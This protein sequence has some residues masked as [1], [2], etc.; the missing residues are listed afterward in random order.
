MLF[1]VLLQ[2]S[3]ITF[4]L[5]TRICLN[6]DISFDVSELLAGHLV[7]QS[8]GWFFSLSDLLLVGWFG[9]LTGIFIVV[10]NVSHR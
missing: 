4:L 5:C 9:W 2:L 10:G 3:F 8:T 7:G 1:N 6:G